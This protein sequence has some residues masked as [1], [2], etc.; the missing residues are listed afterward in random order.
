MGPIHREPDARLLRAAPSHWR[1]GSAAAQA[2]A[3]WV[4]GQR[5]MEEYEQLRATGATL[6]LGQVAGGF[7]SMALFLSL[8]GMEGSD[9]AT[10]SMMEVMLPQLP[11]M[12]DLTAIRGMFVGSGHAYMS[13]VPLMVSTLL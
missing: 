1:A 5:G 8:I 9:T 3:L 11:S 7:L 13:E 6:Q 4:L 12:Q 10:S 2:A